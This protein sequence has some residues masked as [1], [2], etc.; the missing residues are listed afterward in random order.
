[1]MV[2]IA[3]ALD[4]PLEKLFKIIW[5]KRRGKRMKMKAEHKNLRKSRNNIDSTCNNHN[6]AFNFSRNNN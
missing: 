3:Y 4:I 2:R 6:S 1:M 5:W